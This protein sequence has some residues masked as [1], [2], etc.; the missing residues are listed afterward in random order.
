MKYVLISKTKSKK[1]PWIGVELKQN[2]EIKSAGH[3]GAY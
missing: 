2:K 3:E 1:K